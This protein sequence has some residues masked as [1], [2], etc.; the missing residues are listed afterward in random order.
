MKL[1]ARPPLT[2]RTAHRRRALM[3][4]RT[5]VGAEHRLCSRHAFVHTGPCPASASMTQSPGADS[6]GQEA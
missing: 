5:Q 3:Q 2:L 4:G 6:D 1:H